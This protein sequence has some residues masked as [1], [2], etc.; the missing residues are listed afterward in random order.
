MKIIKSAYFDAFRCIADKCPDSCCQQWDVL[1]D[2]ASAEYYLSLSGALGDR[3]RQVLNKE[4]GHYYMTI[5]DG[6]CPMWR[7]D[8]L[9]RIQ[10]ELGEEALCHTCSQFPRLKH[11]YGDFIEYGL[12][13]SCPVAADMILNAPAAPLLESEL[14]GGEAGDYP[15]EDMA[16]LLRSRDTALSML[17]N[18]E[19]IGQTLAVLLLYSC[20]VQGMLDGIDTDFSPEKS[21]L[22][23]RQFARPGDLSE[24]IQFFRQLEIL[25]PRWLQ[26]LD[27]PKPT[28]WSSQLLAFVRYGIERYWLQA[29]SDG[30]LVCRV[31]MILISCLLLKHLGGNTVTTAQAFSKEIENSIENLESI[32]DAAYTHPAFTDDKLLY[33][34][35]T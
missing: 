7:Q 24:F 18:P 16:L 19:N 29:I 6:R 14:P 17:E 34:L 9:C 31:K 3:L 21:L 15:Q 23:A 33:L 26:L 32:Y 11:D 10:A 27:D 5:E 13:L 25:T 1:V 22:T 20:H 28:G 30:D 4:D 2:D 35:M 8:G 12:E